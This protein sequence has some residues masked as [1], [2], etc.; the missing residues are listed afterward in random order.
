MRGPHRKANDVTDQSR[1]DDWRQ[2]VAPEHDALLFARERAGT[3]V[4]V[5]APEVGALLQWAA[6]CVDARTAV[7]IGCAAGVSGLWIVPA[8]A[9]GGVLT[10]IDEDA[11][12]HGLAADAYNHGG[13]DTQVRA[14][15]NE[16]LT[17]LP[18]L[19]DAGYDLGLLQ[20][21][22]EDPELLLDHAV[23]LLRPG[24][25][26]LVR[27]VLDPARDA[28]VAT[29]FLT[30]IT[31]HELLLATTLPMDLGVVLAIRLPEA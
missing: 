25:M 26:L 30:T 1:L 31:R 3:S 27:G 6:E 14:I 2:L 8:L 21:W 23:R 4:A 12:A 29:D 11:H 19:T 24:G 28:D 18:R 17:V 10:S 20:A 5:P 13:I 9:E 15:L 7:E 16:P 22:D